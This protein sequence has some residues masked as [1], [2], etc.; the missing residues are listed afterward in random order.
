M[1]TENLDLILSKI[2]K[3]LST[4][5][6]LTK[7]LE[8]LESHFK[9]NQSNISK[10]IKDIQDFGDV[11]S[12][13]IKALK[14]YE[15][16][17][18]K[19]NVSFNKISEYFNEGALK[20]KDFISKS[21]NLSNSFISF[22]SDMKDVLYSLRET[23][24][25]F[26]KLGIFIGFLYDGLKYLTEYVN[27]LKIVSK[28]TVEFENGLKNIVVSAS[29]AG[30]TIDSFSLFVDKFSGVFNRWGIPT[31]IRMI[32]NLRRNG[33]ELYMMGLSVKEVNEYFGLF[34][35]QQR[36]FDGRRIRTENE[37][38]EMFKEQI[39]M[40]YEIA[41]RTGRSLEEVF[42]S[43]SNKLKEPESFF[44]LETLTEKQRKEMIKFLEIFPSLTPMFMEGIKKGA[45]QFSGNFINYATTMGSELENIFQG[46]L[47]GLHDADSAAKIIVRTMDSFSDKQKRM[48]A[49]QN[50]SAFLAVSRLK[51]EANRINSLN[52]SF[53]KTDKL[54][55]ILLNFESFIT[56]IRA[57]LRG[58]ILDLLIGNKTSEE[59]SK[60]F[61]NG[62]NTINKLFDNFVLFIENLL[63]NFGVN[64]SFGFESIF[65]AISSIGDTIFKSILWL[66][67][68]ERVNSIKYFFSTLLKFFESFIS[69]VD[70]ISPL[71]KTENLALLGGAGAGIAALT[72]GK[73]P[74]FGE[75]M[76]E[77]EK[78]SG[79]L[80]GLGKGNF[81]N[82]L[83]KFSILGLTGSF[84][85]DFISNKI[86]ENINQTAGD[87]IRNLL[88]GAA[89]GASFGGLLGS[90]VPGIGTAIGG[91]IGGVS[92]AIVNTIGNSAEEIKKL[93]PEF[94][95]EEIN[96]SI[97]DIQLPPAA[98]LETT[99][100]ELRNI[101]LAMN[102]LNKNIIE[103]YK[104]SRDGNI[105]S[106][107]IY[108]ENKNTNEK[109]G[110]IDINFMNNIG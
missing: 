87:I 103:M 17:T 48:I 4:T 31:M 7:V 62:K 102:Q 73:K 90:I 28:S 39:K 3:H 49:L 104:L 101:N 82:K 26:T 21:I 92:G 37:L 89:T 54:S 105:I 66:T 36:I 77:V 93:I 68:P 67:D 41:K 11:T 14:D 65:E 50:E 79:V 24:G 6:R 106:N 74:S 35:E 44:A 96:K 34:L 107:A 15:L 70:T 33:S 71:F 32:E 53:K 27:A 2:E 10:T 110:S 45:I 72:M 98:S 108:Q 9:G 51:A 64:A 60:I 23:I 91:T 20:L 109:L 86:S 69:F 84:L 38:Q 58:K 12:K 88:T 76:S 97:S 30:M 78:S 40:S 81:L 61:E 43:I 95:I 57:S 63:K 55:E 99:N 18:R 42:E 100:E 8:S 83:T 85:G 46:L 13:S 19:I 56:D 22:N 94:D 16:S 25:Y 52:Q 75:K 1:A 59:I 47:S 5:P 80:G 29:K